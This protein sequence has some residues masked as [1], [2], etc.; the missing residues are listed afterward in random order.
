MTKKAILQNYERKKQIIDQSDYRQRHP[1]FVW[2]VFLISL[3]LKKSVKTKIKKLLCTIQ[4]TTVNEVRRD[5]K[6]MVLLVL[7]NKNPIRVQESTTEI[8]L[9]KRAPDQYF[10]LHLDDNSKVVIPR[11]DILM[12]EDVDTVIRNRIG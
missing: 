10:R 11:K 3:I 2:D 4:Q 9:Q 6:T 5:G 8:K 12:M 7:H 1:Y